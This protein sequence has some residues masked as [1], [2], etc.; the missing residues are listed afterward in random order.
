MLFIEAILY[1]SMSLYSS[2]LENNV[3]ETIPSY[4][5]ANHAQLKEM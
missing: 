5:F 1:L 4:S 2:Y 3:I